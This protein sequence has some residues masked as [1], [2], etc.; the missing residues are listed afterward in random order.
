MNNFDQ[1]SGVLRFGP[2]EIFDPKIQISKKK[3][4]YIVLTKG[5]FI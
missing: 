4:V 5:Q 3:P 2:A 1:I